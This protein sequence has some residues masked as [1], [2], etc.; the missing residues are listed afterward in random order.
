[1]TAGALATIVFLFCVGDVCVAST[2]LTESYSSLFSSLSGDFSPS[3]TFYFIYFPFVTQ[4]EVN[5]PFICITNIEQ[6]CMPATWEHW[7]YKCKC[8]RLLS[9]IFPIPV[10]IK[11]IKLS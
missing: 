8:N 10:K 9:L 6:C 5:G 11:Q 2:F 4:A 1:M 7:G 3:I